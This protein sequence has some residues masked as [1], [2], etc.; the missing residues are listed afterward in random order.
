MRYVAL[1]RAVNLGGHR[2]VGMA[3]L[4]ELL[5]FLGYSDVS[6]YIQS[7]NALFTSPEDDAGAL[8]RE[9]EQAIEQRFGMDVP[10]LLRTP[11]ELAAV[12]AGNP[13][14]H[15]LT[16]PSRFYVAFLSGQPDPDA[17]AQIDA[18]QFV[19]EE[20]APGER[21]MYVWYPNGLN[22]SKL[23]NTF[24]EKHLGVTATSRNWNTVN[25]LLELARD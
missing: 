9:I 22:A 25:K 20:F 12:I 14:P 15:A 1:L 10:V 13:F 3:E 4:R 11:N 21:A 16:S 17:L 24:W 18:Q 6:T 2:K 7:G 5:S 8:E 23:S 19:P